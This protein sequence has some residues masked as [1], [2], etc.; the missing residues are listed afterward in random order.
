MAILISDKIDFKIKTIIKDKE[1]HYIRIKGYMSRQEF[2]EWLDSVE[3]GEV[4]ENT[5]RDNLLMR[6]FS[7]YGLWLA[8][9]LI[10]PLGMALN[11]TPCVLPM[12]PV[13]LMVIGTKDAKRGRGLLLGGVYG[14]GMALAYGALGCIVVL[15]GRQFGELNSNPWFNGAVALLFIALGLAM[16]DVFSIDF[17]RF[18][19]G[20]VSGNAKR[21]SLAAAF[22]MGALAAVLAGACVAPV[23]IWVLVLATDLYG[24]GNFAGLVLPFLLGLGMGLPW[25]FLGGGLSKIPRPGQ[26]MVRVRQA[27]GVL[28]IALGVY[29]GSVFWRQMAG[30]GGTVVHDGWE[31]RLDV[32]LERSK[33]EGKPLFID[34]WGISCKNCALMDRTVFADEGVQKRLKERYIPVKFLADDLSDPQVAAAVSHFSVQG[35]PTFVITN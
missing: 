17:T 24:A 7:A 33:R 34:F 25:P 8:M 15:T 12:I 4:Q 6:I 13:T 5:E 1:G 21:G 18:R 32:A 9:L 14:L 27:M 20:N 11:L 3:K 22:M 23:L 28:I 29:Y 31:T 16:F 35:F 10:I 26:W 19:K 30:N 2:V